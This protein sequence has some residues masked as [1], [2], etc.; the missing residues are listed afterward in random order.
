M[1]EVLEMLCMLADHLKL[2]VCTREGRWK[3]G[4]AAVL[5]AAAAGVG[6]LLAGPIGAGVGGAV[7]GI[8]GACVSEPVSQ[9]IRDLT[10]ELKGYL[11][12]AAKKVLFTA[13]IL[14]EGASDLI[15]R[16]MERREVEE[17]LVKLLCNVFQN[18]TLMLQYQG[19][20][21]L[22][23]QSGHSSNPG[24]SSAPQQLALW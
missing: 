3:L 6:A 10:P 5:G 13:N 16:V 22:I 8:I 12:S 24:L 7:G 9:A 1:D 11:V 17:L 2:M 19:Q 18:H 4:T 15:V 20:H 14:W 23:S 21:Q